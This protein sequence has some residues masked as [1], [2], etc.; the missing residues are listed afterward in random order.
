MVVNA[1]SPQ[2][3]LANPFC[4]TTGWTVRNKPPEPQQT[5]LSRVDDQNKAR[6]RACNEFTIPDAASDRFARGSSKQRNRTLPRSSPV[7]VRKS[8]LREESAEHPIHILFD[9]R[10]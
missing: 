10:R 6:N 7:A 1:R 8:M 5:F 3:V 2:S 9:P 4:L